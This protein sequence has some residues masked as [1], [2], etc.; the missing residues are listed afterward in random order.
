MG[1]QSWTGLSDF[2]FSLPLKFGKFFNLTKLHCSHLLQQDVNM[3]SR[4][5]VKMIYDN[6][7]EEFSTVLH[8]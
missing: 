5:T 6:T 1:R 8:A 3:Y 4:I 2:Y 7:C